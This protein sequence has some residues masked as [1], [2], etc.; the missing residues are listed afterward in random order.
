VNWAARLA[1]NAGTSVEQ[2][3]RFYV[4][5][6]P[7]NAEMARNLQ[8][9]GGEKHERRKPSYDWSYMELLS[10]QITTIKPEDYLTD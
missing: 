9:F 4:R 1:E 7:L 10:F 3:E 5:N 8:S 6:L 2:I